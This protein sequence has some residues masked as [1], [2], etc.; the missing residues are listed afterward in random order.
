M[1][2]CPPKH[3][4]MGITIMKEDKETTAEENQEIVKTEGT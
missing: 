4:R 3:L 1:Q 2:E